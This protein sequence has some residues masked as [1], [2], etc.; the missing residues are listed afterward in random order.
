MLEKF[1]EDRDATLISLSLD[2]TVTITESSFPSPS[3]TTLLAEM[4]GSLGL[5]LGVGVVQIIIYVSNV[6]NI[7]RIKNFAGH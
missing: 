5:W 3:F 4:G 7:R 1:S 2:Q 6:T